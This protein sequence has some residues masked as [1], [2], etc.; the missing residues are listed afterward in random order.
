MAGERIILALDVSTARE[1]LRLVETCRDQVGAFKIGMELFHACGPSILTQARDAGAERI[2]YDGKL[3]DIPNSVAGAARGIGRLGVWLTTVHALGGTTM[4]RAAQAAAAEGAAAAGLPAPKV[5]AITLV[6][7][8]DGAVMN[9]ELGIPGEP[10]AQVVRLAR[11]AQDAG[12]SG[13]VASPQEATAIRA[14]CGAGFLLVTPGVRPAGAEAGDQRR[15]STPGQA[16]RAGADYLVIG[17]SVT[18]AAD[19]GAA[20]RAIN[21]E[22]EA[23]LVSLAP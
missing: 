13:V 17:R 22:I 3:Y 18:Q 9:R 2:F 19:P 11:I 8:I 7:S 12:L 10:D 23:A 16:V 4:M 6:T 14:A 15:V 5:I 20:L 21:D 1:A